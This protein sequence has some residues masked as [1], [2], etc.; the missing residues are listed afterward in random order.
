MVIKFRNKKKKKRKEYA[1]KYFFTIKIKESNNGKKKVSFPMY[2]LYLSVN[3]EL[4]HNIYIF[5]TKKITIN[6]NHIK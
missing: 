3:C 1:P 5:L 6:H 2:P 4:K